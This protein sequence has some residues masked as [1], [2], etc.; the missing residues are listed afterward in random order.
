MVHQLQLRFN[1]VS[2]AN[3]GSLYVSRPLATLA[4]AV[5]PLTTFAVLEYNQT[6]RTVN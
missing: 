1:L 3:S 4:L 6:V 2:H 5:E